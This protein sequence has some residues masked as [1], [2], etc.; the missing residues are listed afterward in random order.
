MISCSIRFP[1]NA[2]SDL[3]F[4][5]PQSA[6]LH[7]TSCR[8]N[9]RILSIISL[10]DIYFFE[11][12]VRSKRTG[13]VPSRPY[14]TPAASPVLVSCFLNEQVNNQRWESARKIFVLRCWKMAPWRMNSDLPYP[15][16]GYRSPLT[17]SSNPKA[18]QLKCQSESFCS[19]LHFPP[20]PV[21]LSSADVLPLA[22]VAMPLHKPSPVSPS[23]PLFLF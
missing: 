16:H 1:Q 3:P 7:N 6:F 10:V 2:R 18:P 13:T 9:K 20:W 17:S 12:T 23:C 8:W 14:C 4:L 5:H 15:G 19:L 22:S 21:S 11:Y